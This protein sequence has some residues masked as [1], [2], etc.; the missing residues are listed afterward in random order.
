LY[1]HLCIFIRSNFDVKDIVPK[2][3]R[4]IGSTPIEYVYSVERS[5]YLH[6]HIMLVLDTTKPDPL[7]LK[8]QQALKALKSC[9]GCEFNLRKNKDSYYHLLNDPAELDDAVTRYSY[10]AKIN[11]KKHLPLHIK[12][13]FN[14]SRII[15]DQILNKDE[16]MIKISRIPASQTFTCDNEG[17]ADSFNIEIKNQ[18]LK[19]DDIRLCFAVHDTVTDQSIGCYRPLI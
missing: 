12:K 6:I 5:Y 19:G 4:A 11:Q 2:I 10:L 18:R 16:S 9:H 3:K 14:T 1:G 17:V 7:F 8:V 13:T 15:K